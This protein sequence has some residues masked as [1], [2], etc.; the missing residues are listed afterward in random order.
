[1]WPHRAKRQGKN[2]VVMLS[3][4]E[5]ERLA[6]RKARRGSL[7]QFFARSPLHGLPLDL[8]RSSDVGR[9]IDW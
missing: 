4:D 1:M 3:A 9:D 7:S 6:A 5:N 2:T 8:E